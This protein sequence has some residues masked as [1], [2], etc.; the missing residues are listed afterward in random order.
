MAVPLNP[1]TLLTF[2][3]EMENNRTWVEAANMWL[4][5]TTHKRTHEQDA[6]KVAW[7]GE[8]W[9][10]YLLR[11]ISIDVVR[12]LGEA[13]RMES[14]E[15]T[16]NRYLALVRAILRR[17]VTEWE[18][19][20][21]APHVRLYRERGRR[22][23]WATP[24]EVERLL[25]ELPEHH[26]P[27]VIFALATGLRHSNVV[28]LRWDQVDMTRRTAWIFG[29][30]TKNGED[31]QVSLNDSAMAVLME[32]RAL[33]GPWVFS[34]R[35]RPVRRLNTRAW[36]RALQRAGLENF[37]WHDLRHT[38][39]SWLVQRGVPLY[40]VQEMGGWKSGAMVRRY[41]HLSPAV[42]LQ[43]ARVIDGQLRSAVLTDGD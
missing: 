31:L 34:Y 42:N 25:A 20:D 12:E 43:H 10:G 4:S 24:A 3:V 15:A 41:A 6:R 1:A 28:G 27:A 16:A 9:R 23:R 19:L 14:S 17:A 36:Y 32:R 2:G 26:R 30:Q 37:R 7:I 18:W 13:K 39:A 40:A 38:W 8:R 21:R 11:D 29:D 33:G 22:V 5:E 35:G